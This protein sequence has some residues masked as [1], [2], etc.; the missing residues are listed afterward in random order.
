MYELFRVGCR[1]LIYKQ[2]KIQGLQKSVKIHEKLK[3]VIWWLLKYGQNFQI[4]LIR[5]DALLFIFIFF[6]CPA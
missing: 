1:F 2:I 6:I 5:H 3:G 4:D